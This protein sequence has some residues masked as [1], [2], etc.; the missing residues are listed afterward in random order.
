MKLFL[1]IAAL[2]LLVLKY[3]S[4]NFTATESVSEPGGGTAT[5]AGIVYTGDTIGNFLTAAPTY[6]QD[7]KEVLIYHR[8]RGMHNRT[9]N[10]KVEG[11]ISE[12][13]STVS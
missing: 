12:V 9:N 6:A 7:E 5:A 1:L 13:A 8:N 10:V 3:V 11:V 4:K 2:I